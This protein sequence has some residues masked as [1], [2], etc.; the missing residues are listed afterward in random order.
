MLVP[1]VKIQTH[2]VGIGII[3]TQCRL[4]RGLLLGIS[5]PLRTEMD[6]MPPVSG[7]DMILCRI[8]RYWRDMCSSFTAKM[9][10]VSRV[11]LLSPPHHPPT[12]STS[13]VR[14]N[15]SPQRRYP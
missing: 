5:P 10:V 12:P 9:V 7:P 6:N 4:I 14:R 1:L 15:F 13:L 8:L 3:P 11:V 2:K